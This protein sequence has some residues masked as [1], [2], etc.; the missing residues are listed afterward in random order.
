MRILVFFL[1]FCSATPVV[2][3]VIDGDVT[4]RGD[5]TISDKVRVDQGGHLII[6]PDS[7]ISFAAGGTLE[8]AGRMTARGVTFSGQGW[9]GIVLKGTGVDTL[10]TESA[11]RDARIGVQVIGGEPRLEGLILEQNDVGVELRQQTEATLAGA[12]FRNNRK[13]GL[14]VKDGSAAAIL[15]NRFERNG[16]YGAYIF[17]STPRRF[18]GNVFSH[19]QTALMVAYSGSNPEITDNCFDH[20]RIAIRV[21]KGAKPKIS[22]SDVSDNE[23]GISLYRRADPLIERNLLF[24]NDIGVKVAFSSYPVISNNDF[25][26]NGKAVFLE[27]QSSQWER[28]NGNKARQA[29]STRSAF[30]SIEKSATGLPAPPKLDG[31]VDARQN[32]WGAKAAGEL[33][34]NGQ[35]KNLSFIDDGRDRPTFIEEGREYPLDQ[36][37]VHPWRRQPVFGAPE[38][39]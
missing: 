27:F 35:G 22:G 31:T 6:E 3:Q 19:E 28:E 8:V 23:V 20:N 30:G 1:L 26:E 21:E 15:N 10:I 38:K 11:I 36:V 29:E 7:R 25:I 33:G 2:A 39:K 14:F 24:R 37:D 12:T 17:R 34:E 5:K 9:N 18:S 13:V 32:W 4:W 16:K